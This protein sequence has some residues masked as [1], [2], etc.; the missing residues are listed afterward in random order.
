[1]VI[2]IGADQPGLESCWLGSPDP[3]PLGCAP[4]TTTDEDLHK[5]VHPVRQQLSIL[6]AVAFTIPGIVLRLADIHTSDPL[7]AFLFGIAIVSAAFLL[8]WAGEVAQLDISAGLAIA[9]LALVGVLPEYAVGFVFAAKGG[10]DYQRFGA[11]CQ[12]AAE[13]AAHLESSCTLALAN[14]TGANRLLI[15]VGWSMVVAVGWW[16]WR[17]RGQRV[18]GVD[19]ERSHAVELSFLAV[20]TVYSLTL[21]LK[22]SITLVDAVVLVAIFVGYTIRIARAP[23]EEPHLVGPSRW[24]GG[25]PVARRRATVVVLFLLA[26]G[27]ILLCA[28]HFADALVATGR[29]FDISD[30]LLV[31]WLAPIASEAPE[32]LVAGLFA[33]RLNTDAG[34]GTLVSSKVNQWT[35]LIGTLPIVFAVTSHSLHGLPFL[36]T[37]RGEVLL[38]AAQSLFAVAILANLSISTKEAA[39]L[40]TLFWAQFLVGAVVPESAHGVERSV[41]SVIYLVLAAA[42]V[43]RQRAHVRPM[44]HDGFRA[45][46]AEL[47]AD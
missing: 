33:W 14:M 47:A 31:Q 13:H 43:L 16:R 42:I 35:L 40:F 44:F 27:V 25:F 8:A 28:E 41:V 7:D 5:A 39:A 37:A 26:A 10:H 12:P 29:S 24:I 22:R 23:A 45:P 11:L 18:E 6:L 38:T 34:L 3:A 2:G 17:K 30:F 1:M 36:A 15:G 32:L 21:P 4:V 20:A 46:Y 19:L 9:L